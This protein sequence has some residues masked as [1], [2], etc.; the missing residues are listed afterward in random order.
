MDLES[1][2]IMKYDYFASC[3]FVF[4][5]L[6]HLSRFTKKTCGTWVCAVQPTDLQIHSWFHLAISGVGCLEDWGI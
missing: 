1:M 3:K 6:F 4:V 5:T 2:G